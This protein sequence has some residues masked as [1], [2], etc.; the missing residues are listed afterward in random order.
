MGY[1][2]RVGRVVSAFVVPNCT[3]SIQPS[4]VPRHDVLP[5]GSNRT[6]L[7]FGCHMWIALDLQRDASSK[8]LVLEQIKSLDT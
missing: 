4:L 5:L 7:Y 1:H 6:S 2:G 3:N 8:R